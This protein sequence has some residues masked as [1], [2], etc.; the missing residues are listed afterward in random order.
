MNRFGITS[1]GFFPYF[2]KLHSP[3]RLQR[4]DNLKKN[5]RENIG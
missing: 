2:V 1:T 4:N 3:E 5:L